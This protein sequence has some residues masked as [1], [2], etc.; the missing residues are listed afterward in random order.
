M[1]PKPPEEDVWRQFL[2]EAAAA[3][4]ALR[5]ATMLAALSTSE[6][7]ALAGTQFA[8]RAAAALLGVT[9]LEVL[10]RA[11][12]ETLLE[13]DPADWSELRGPLSAC[14]A[15]LADAVTTL[16]Q[17][18]AS[19]ARLEHTAAIDAALLGLG[20]RVTVTPPPTATP[21][22]APPSAPEAAP[23]DDTVWV[24]QVDADMVEPFLEEATERIEGLAQKLLRLESAP[25]DVELIREIFRDLHTLKGSSAFVGL[26]RMN[27]LAH[28][29]EDLVGQL[30]DGARRVDRPIVDALLGALDGLRALLRAASAVDPRSGTRIDVPIEAAVARLRAP[31]AVATLD[32][33]A[34]TTSS[35]AA[36]A[37]TA[38]GASAPAVAETQKTLRVDFDKLDTLLNLVGELVLA[39]ARLHASV[40]SVAVLGRELEA[41]V[42]R[43]RYNRAHAGR[44]ELDDVDRV[45]RILGELA[46]NLGGG[47][48]ALDHVGDELRQ[49]VMKLRMLPIARVFTKYHRT[50]REL[51]FSL[52]KKA[53]LDL[54]GADT[55]LDKV[56]LE[57]LDDPLLHLTRNA[58]DHGIEAPEARRAAG[59]PEEGVITLTARRRGNQI[60]VEVRD[61]GAGIEPSRLRQ[62]AREKQLAT[63]EELAD[64]DDRAVLDLIFRPGFSTAARVTDL[65]G[66]GVGMDVVRDTITK[67]S[68]TIE[69]ASSPGLGTTFTLRLPLT[70]AIVQ[71][72]LVRIAGE[73]YA[74]PLD[75]VV[76]TLALPPEQIQ[77]VYDREVI[78]LGR[79]AADPEE[80]A[81]ESVAQVPLLWAADALELPRATPLELGGASDVPVVLVDAAGETYAL[82]VERLLGKREIVLKSL[83][84]LLSEVPCAAGATLIGERVAVILDVVQLVQRGL[85]RPAARPVPPSTP[86]TT[87]AAARRRPRILVAEDSDVVRESLRRVLEAHGYEVVTA[88]D[89]AEA[90]ELAT[91]DARG[92]DLVSTDVLMPH[93]DGYELARALRAQPRHKDVPMIMVTS[94]AEH[95][96]RVRGFDAGVDDYLTKPLDAAE[97]VRA[98]DKH[99]GQR[100]RE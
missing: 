54:E 65:S 82:A 70:L 16:C 83:G 9:P 74:L 64:M 34:A 32:A 97:L 47:A 76:R 52:G 26:R 90:L 87:T 45:Q 72:L 5:A 19:G 50:V 79:T 68:G 86:T 93:L 11:I 2:V 59:K 57:Q 91:R 51:S 36:A 100:R 35:A 85:A 17:P 78:F 88:R 53:R 80:A 22:A 49:Q 4:E 6:L 46:A 1:R 24:P 61:D 99:L 48:N 25:G 75:V 30:R 31:N 62:K 33:A 14:A 40:S 7:R 42:R 95:L 84:A 15:A 28:A 41:L 39:K 12:E 81:V 21:A 10:A 44:L 56:L 69:L 20:R 8:L 73:D 77:R 92:F 94:K 18:D 98:I 38:V 3:A 63:D 55:E 71:V 27:T 13:R 66:R 23:P 29:A 96:D 43:A 58:I 60:L 67:L 89:G 37:P